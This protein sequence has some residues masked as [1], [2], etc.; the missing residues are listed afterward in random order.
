MN[1]ICVCSIHM[2][3][4]ANYMAIMI[5]I[6]HSLEETDKRRT[7]VVQILHEV[8]DKLSEDGLNFDD[9]NQVQTIVDVLKQ[10]G[11]GRDGIFG[12]MDDT[13]PQS[14]INEIALLEKTSVFSDLVSLFKPKNKKKRSYMA[15]MLCY[16]CFT[17]KV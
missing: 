15:T 17:P 8:I 9:D 5:A 16:K 11:K 7:S 2:K 3:L 10:L 13:I 4:N 6:L 1:I 12:T 14:L